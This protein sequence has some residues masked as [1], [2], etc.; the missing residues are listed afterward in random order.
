MNLP[1]KNARKMYM[2]AASKGKYQYV[3]DCSLYESWDG[4]KDNPGEIKYSLLIDDNPLNDTAQVG[5]RILETSVEIFDD[6][7]FNKIV[8][9]YFGHTEQKKSF[10]IKYVC[11]VDVNGNCL[12]VDIQDVVGRAYRNTK[13]DTYTAL[14]VGNG[15]NLFSTGEASLG[16]RSTLNYGC[17]FIGFNI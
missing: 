11:F 6:S 16:T 5:D 4:Y 15:V 2:A 3:C 12:H 7:V 14:P 8:F 17:E 10:I 9:N 13:R 1:S